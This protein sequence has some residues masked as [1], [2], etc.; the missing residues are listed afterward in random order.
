MIVRKSPSRSLVQLICRFCR[1]VTSFCASY[2]LSKWSQK[3]SRKIRA[4]TGCNESTAFSISFGLTTWLSSTR[5]APN[6]RRGTEHGKTPIAL[7]NRSRSSRSTASPS[8]R[9]LAGSYDA[10]PL[11]IPSSSTSTAGPSDSG[12]C[13]ATRL[14]TCR[15]ADDVRLVGWLNQAMAQSTRTAARPRATLRRLSCGGQGGRGN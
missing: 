5:S 11:P 14:Q 7:S 8:T 15:C 12:R 10:R 6:I 2:L 3:A 4:T 13:T 9:G 1:R